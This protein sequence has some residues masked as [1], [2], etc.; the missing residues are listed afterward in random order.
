MRLLGRVQLT[1]GGVVS[2]FTLGEAVPT[3]PA[4]SLPCAVNGD[5]TCRTAGAGA[6]ARDAVKPRSKPPQPCSTGPFGGPIPHADRSRRVGSTVLTDA[7]PR[8]VVFVDLA[9]L[10]DHRLCD[11]TRQGDF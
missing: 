2:T 11:L 8:R 10:C 7:Y 5:D 4:M 9:P 1:A 3:L 6:D